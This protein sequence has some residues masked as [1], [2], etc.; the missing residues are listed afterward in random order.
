MITSDR[1]YYDDGGSGY[2]SHIEPLL[3]IFNNIP[4][5]RK[6]VELGMGNYST[7]FLLENCDIL[8]SVEMQEESWFN[9]TRN[10]YSNH[11]RW[12]SALDLTEDAYL[13]INLEDVSFALSDGH[14]STRPEAVT[15]F[16][17]HGVETIVAHDTESTWYGWERIPVE[18]ERDYFKYMFTKIAPYT[19]VWTKNAKLIEALKALDGQGKVLVLNQPRGLGDLIFCQTLG[20]HFKHYNY[21]VIFNADAF[22]AEALNRVYP[23]M[24]FLSNFIPDSNRELVVL[25]E[26]TIIPLRFSDS[27]CK[28]LYKDCMKSKYWMHD[29]VWQ[30]W[31]RNAMWKRDHEKENALFDFLGLSADTEFTLVNT[32]YTT[33]MNYQVDIDIKNLPGKVINM[34]HIPGF[35][36]FDWAYVIQ[37]AKAIHTV[38]TAIIYMLEL[39]D[40]KDTPVF[41]YKREPLEHDHSY[42]DYLLTK[43]N[44]LL[45]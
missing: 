23:D 33:A 1:S 4:K 29:L 20:Q 10:T 27:I 43:P 22:Y 3:F 26:K 36:L 16:M 9:E 14:G 41:I 8:L 37:K 32:F 13:R 6:A 2:G 15:H 38:S 44:Y 24:L 21:R 19:T 28:V 5:P 42:Y 31:K 45:V 39:L 35:S 40:I 25:Q 11:T 18:V 12:I 7:P 34:K 17:K 30:S